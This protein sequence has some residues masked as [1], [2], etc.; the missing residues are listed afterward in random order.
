M[1]AGKTHGPAVA[2]HG[3]AGAIA[4]QL[5][6]SREKQYRASLESTLDASYAV[7]EQGG[8]S[9]DAVTTA[10]RLLEEDPL[11]NAGR[12]AALN[13]DGA[14]ELDAAIMDGRQQR[15]GAV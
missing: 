4:R 7:L 15:A 12:G 10:V 8:S 14:V 6:E 1:H 11:F 9:L 13:R 5:L 2:I 3:G